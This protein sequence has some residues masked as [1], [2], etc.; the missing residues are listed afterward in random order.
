M[1]NNPQSQPHM[2]QNPLLFLQSGAIPLFPI[3]SSIHLK[4]PAL[5]GTWQEED[6]CG[7]LDKQLQLCLSK[8][9]K[10]ALLPLIPRPTVL[11]TLENDS[12]EKAVIKCV[13]T[14]WRFKT[15][16]PCRHCGAILR[17]FSLVISHRYLHRG[18]RSHLCQC[19]R[20]FKHKLHLLRHCLQHSEAAGYIC[21]SCGETF[22]G[23]KQ[24]ARHLKGDYHRKRNEIEHSYCKPEQKCTMPFTCDC[25]QVFFRPSAF[26]WHQLKNMSK[27]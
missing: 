27:Q 20:A 25:G 16:Y 4:P 21:V 19:G 23:S 10:T 26:I 22:I 17:Q 6:T 3:F 9:E 8:T 14:N 12:H 24:L 13:N 5:P 1:H 2:L 7:P 18:H 11:D 15:C